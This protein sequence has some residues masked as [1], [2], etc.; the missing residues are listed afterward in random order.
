MLNLLANPAG[1]L[2]SWQFFPR[3]NWF[4]STQEFSPKISLN[5]NSGAYSIKTADNDLDLKEVLK[6]RKRIFHYEFSGR[7]LSLRSERDQFDG[8]ADHLMIIDNESQECVG[9]YRILCSQFTEKFYSA[10]EFH[11][12]QILDLSGTKIELSRACILKE[13]RNGQVLNLLWKGIAAYAQRSGADWLFGLS[14]VQTTDIKE[15]VTINKYLESNNHCGNEYNVSPHADFKIDDFE[16]H[17]SNF[18]PIADHNNDKVADLLPPLF[19]LYLKAGAKV[20]PSPVIDSKMR[21]ADWLT[22][23]KLKELSPAFARRFMR[24]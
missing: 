11:L 19:Q 9:V 10:T 14:S 4:R 18:F 22:V 6:I 3:F 2:F 15:I 1:D 7:M 12:E 13:H 21:C 16:Y 8:E 20:C 24:T 5:I 17:S 23:L